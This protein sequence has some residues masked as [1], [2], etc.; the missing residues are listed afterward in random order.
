MI[1]PMGTATSPTGFA[2]LRVLSLESRRAPE[3]AKLIATFGGNA[4]VAPSMREVP[5]E[6][7]TEAQGFTRALLAGDFDLLILLT[8]VGTRALT[9][10]AE[11][12]CSR[13]DFICA[14]RRLPV[15]ARGPK[16][17]AVLKELEVPVALAVPEPNT[18]RE[19]LAALDGKTETLP[20]QGK[21]VAVQE[22]GASNPELLAG[23][24]E[25]GAQ[26]TRVPVYEWALP[27]DTGPLRAAVTS[28]ANG[29]VDVA[30]FTTSVQVVHLL[31]IAE[32][33]HLAEKIRGAFGKILVGSIGPVTSEALREHDLPVD[34]EPSH[35]KMGFLVNELAQRSAEL[36]QRKRAT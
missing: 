4:T 19:L 16:P 8:G 7:N 24:S 6:S 31:K 14:L 10:V 5:I 21:R 1:A 22:Y 15:V 2:G 17:M 9:R 25:R 18:W 33:M 13:E 11:T 35:P 36:L 27:E 34:F 26:V 20:I 23:L 3:M 32:E 30:V 29:N 12:V 28:I